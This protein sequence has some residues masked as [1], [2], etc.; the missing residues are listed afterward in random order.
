M[1]VFETDA[2]SVLV[3]EAIAKF[4]LDTPSL[5]VGV[6]PALCVALQVILTV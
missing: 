4:G 5:F 1:P 3:P 6:E 2:T